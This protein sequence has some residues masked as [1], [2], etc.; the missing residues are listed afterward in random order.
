MDRVHGDVMAVDAE[1]LAGA[2]NLR[3][4]LVPG[5][6]AYFGASFVLRDEHVLLQ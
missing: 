2:S 4:P 3:G 5:A 1:G 6:A